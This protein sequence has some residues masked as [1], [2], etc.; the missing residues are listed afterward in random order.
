MKDKISLGIVV[1]V[2]FI[3]GGLAMFYFNKQNANTSVVK[4]ETGEMVCKSCNSTVIVEDGS[5][6]FIITQTFY[7]NYFFPIK[8]KSHS[9]KYFTNW[10]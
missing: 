1:L 8:R 5:L 3:L 4:T 2:S 9:I 10:N 7:I 6:S